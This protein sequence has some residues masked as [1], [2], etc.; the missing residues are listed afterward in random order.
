[1]GQKQARQIVID[2]HKTQEHQ[3]QPAGLIVEEQAHEEQ[4]GIPHESLVLEQAEE[5]EDNGEERPEIKLGEQQRVGLV[6]CE[7]VLQ[8]LQ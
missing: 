1:M 8:E 4:E 7:Q 2:Y 6:E 3:E 5:G